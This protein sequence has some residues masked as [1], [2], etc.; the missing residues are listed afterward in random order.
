MTLNFKFRDYDSDTV[1]KFIVENCQAE[2]ECRHLL[3]SF[4]RTFENLERATNDPLEDNEKSYNHINQLISNKLMRLFGLPVDIYN[5]E[6]ED[7][8]KYT[9]NN[10]KNLNEI[11]VKMFHPRRGN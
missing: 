10:R 8:F 5:W 9:I 3:D 4:I 7:Y 1:V 11:W 2:Y 6:F